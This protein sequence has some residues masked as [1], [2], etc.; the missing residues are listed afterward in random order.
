MISYRAGSGLSV[1]AS[2]SGRR[3]LVGVRLRR[4]VPTRNAWLKPAWSEHGA[5]TQSKMAMPRHWTRAHDGAMECTPARFG[6][7]D[8]GGRVHCG[9][10]VPEMDVPER[11]A[12]RPAA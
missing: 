12:G 6:D 3:N 2:A 9:D 10:R 11:T 4:L 1:A 5:S 7:K 8:R